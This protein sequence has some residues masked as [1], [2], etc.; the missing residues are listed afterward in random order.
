MYIQKLIADRNREALI[1]AQNKL[2]MIAINTY[3]AYM[4]WIT[5]KSKVYIM[6]I[7]FGLITS[8]NTKSRSINFMYHFDFAAKVKQSHWESFSCSKKE[9]KKRMMVRFI[10][11]L[12]VNFV[13][14]TVYFNSCF[15]L[16]LH[17]FILMKGATVEVFWMLLNQV[18]FASA[19]L[20]YTK[21][22]SRL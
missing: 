22:H 6:K 18:L 16:R 14:T 2:M 20:T 19:S 1:E 12:V 11:P 8:C 21:I 17:H 5:T 9:K 7:F 13:F 4:M 10:M 15:F 3:R